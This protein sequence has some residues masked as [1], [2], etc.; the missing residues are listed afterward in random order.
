MSP[1]PRFS[2]DGAMLHRLKSW[3]RDRI[4]LRYGF[5]DDV[6][7]RATSPLVLHRRLDADRKRRLREMAVLFLHAKRMEPAGGLELDEVMR[8]RI[9]A[10]ACE[11]IL[12][13]GL[14]SLE[15]F[16][17]LVIYP[18]E[19]IVRDREEVDEDGVVHVGDDVLCGEAWEKGP[20]VLAWREVE[21][22]GRGR[23]YNVVAHE[24]AHKLDLLSG[25]VNGLPPLHECMRTEQWT[26]TFR[27]AYDALAAQLGRG[28]EP[29]L[30]PY[31][32]EDPGE[33][34]AV[35]TEVFFDVP[36]EFA[37]R[38]PALYEQLASFFRQDPAVGA[39]RSAR[40]GRMRRHGSIR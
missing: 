30:D 8:A 31:A 34:F 29:W 21:E 38:Y 9:A 15:G 19:F 17:S 11:P 32:A 2:Y 39:R 36:A 35:C 33:F 14:S 10:L 40:H 16:R 12:E 6:W 5:P 27:A 7:N 28:A 26:R 23:G 18:A 20:V 1:F 4:L 13:L 24:I 25:A 3:R 22:S 37:A